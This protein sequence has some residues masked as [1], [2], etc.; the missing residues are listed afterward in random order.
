ML[1]SE[2]QAGAIDDYIDRAAEMDSL[3]G[4][5]LPMVG[6]ASSDED[7]NKTKD[8]LEAALK[9]LDADL[10][11][12]FLVSDAVTFADVVMLPNV[13][14]LFKYVLG[15]S[16]RSKLPHVEKWIAN[17]AQNEHIGSVIGM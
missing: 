16:M 1:Y 15:T 7:R 11:K 13:L 9:K 4:P 10:Q 12:G 6:P 17:M 5:W 2:A 8:R 14:G 3:A